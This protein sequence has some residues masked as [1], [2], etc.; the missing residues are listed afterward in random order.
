MVN[1]LE[2]M[3]KDIG[4]K[5]PKKKKKSKDE[6]EIFC[7]MLEEDIK[8]VGKIT[9]DEIILKGIKDKVKIPIKNGKKEDMFP[10]D[11]GMKRGVDTMI[12]KN[13][14]YYN[15]GICNFTGEDRKMKQGGSC[16]NFDESPDFIYREELIKNP[17]KYLKKIYKQIVNIIKYYLDLKEEYYSLIAL[18]IIGTYF[19]DCFYSYPYLYF[20]AM[21]SSG[22]SRLL[23]LIKTL[24][25]NGDKLT[26][27]TEAVLFRERGTLCIDEFE[28][29]GKK[30][31]E[32]LRELLNTA[33]KKGGKVKRMKKVKSKKGESQEV[34][35]FEVYRPI[36]IAN[37][38]GLE[39]VLG[40]RCIEMIL[41]RSNDK[42]R[43]K[44]VE[45]FDR[46]PQI[47]GVLEAISKGM[48][49]L[50]SF[51]V[52]LEKAQN[53]WNDYINPQKHQTPQT[54]QTPITPKTPQTPLY[55]LY[56]NINKTNLDGRDL[57]LFL[58]LYLLADMCDVLKETLKISIEITKAKKE[59]DIYESRDVQL[60]DFIS[61]LIDTKDFL[62]VSELNNQFKTF[63]G[64]EE[65]DKWPN[66]WW[67]G[68]AL[69]RLKLI[70]EKKKR[71]GMMVILDIEKAQEKIRMF[72]PLEEIKKPVEVVKIK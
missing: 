6:F 24:S 39:E 64:S 11:G 43:T 15:E 2:K 22:K 55:I 65:K 7:K 32:T 45:N 57:E 4:Y 63:L 28:G 27:L 18:W 72:K 54:P 53:E 31:N 49:S 23:N 13:C 8:R 25:K 44:L 46:T 69:K 20:N 66:T 58:P 26:S 29:I 21:K 60:Y 67:L 3:K 16:A 34:E 71:S 35:E 33:Y 1:D 19:H 37:I 5:E 62:K 51:K 12:C 56:N 47:V 17:K 42:K 38:Y 52:V 14:K 41:E 40:D 59:G 70:R 30:G 68:K 10:E 48:G 50:G 9:D 36:A 61:Q